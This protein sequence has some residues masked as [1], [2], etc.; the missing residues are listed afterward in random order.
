MLQTRTFLRIFRLH[1]FLLLCHSR[2][3]VLSTRRST[4]GHCPTDSRVT[5]GITPTFL[6]LVAP[7]PEVLLPLHL[8]VPRPRDI[9]T[10]LL[11]GLS[12]KL[13]RTFP[14]AKQGSMDE[15]WRRYEC[16]DRDCMTSGASCRILASRFPRSSIA[17]FFCLELDL[18]ECFARSSVGLSYTEYPLM[19]S[20]YG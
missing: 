7:L 10:S 12:Q 6:L 13:E 18:V 5:I 16:N 11:C 17:R 20:Q 14:I 1:T 2:D 19:D 9:K 3:L 15:R 8:V 4:I